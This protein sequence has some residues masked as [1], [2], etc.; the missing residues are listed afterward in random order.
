MTDHI[1]QETAQELRNVCGLCGFA[2]NEHCW[3]GEYSDG[4]VCG[5]WIRRLDDL[6]TQVRSLAAPAA[7]EEG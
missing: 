2:K 3:Q 7:G 1:T 6:E 5:K 4:S